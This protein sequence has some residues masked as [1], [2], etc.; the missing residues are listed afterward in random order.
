MGKTL[1]RPMHVDETTAMRKLGYFASILVDIDLSK[2]IPN[3]I[4]LESKKHGVAFW[5]EVKLGK[6]PEFC[7]HYVVLGNNMA[8]KES[9]GTAMGPSEESETLQFDSVVIVQVLEP[10]F[11]VQTA[12]EIAMEEITGPL[13]MGQAIVVS[14][15]MQ[16]MEMVEYV[17]DVTNVSQSIGEQDCTPIEQEMRYTV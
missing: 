11:M 8:D 6:M 17:D 9:G 4:W 3:K 1:G 10:N 12:D 2:K 16:N 15:E 5:Q 13:S 14:H 7:I